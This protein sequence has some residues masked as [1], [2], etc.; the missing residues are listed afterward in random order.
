MC[1][2]HAP[3]GR[4]TQVGTTTS[5]LTPG[6][7]ACLTDA[8]VSAPIAQYR[9]DSRNLRVA[10][11]GSGA[12]TYFAYDQGGRILSELT[13]TGDPAAPWH[14]L[15]DYVWLDGFLLAQVEYPAGTPTPYYVHSDALGTPRALTN[16]QGALVWSTFQRPFGEVGE[17]ITP[18]PNTGRSVVTN[19]RLPGQY[20]ERLF[21]SLGLQGPYYNWN[22]WYLPGV[23]RYLEPDPIAM[24]GGFNGE[25]GP[26]WYGYALQNPMRFTDASGLLAGVDDLVIGGFLLTVA[27]TGL[28]FGLEENLDPP[29][30]PQPQPSPG[31]APGPGPEPGPEPG[32]GGGGGDRPPKDPC[33][34]QYEEATVRCADAHTCADDTQ[35]NAC[36]ERAWKNYI[37]CINGLP[38]KQN[39]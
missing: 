27:L 36:M 39:P 26:D 33:R 1:L 37:R 3:L 24:A 15:R 11:H 38:W 5:A 2:R 14:K 34:V 6:G 10:R 7:L 22:R 21:G 23:G 8:D 17:T 32:P 12:W 4:L 28:V 31:P 13:P 35:Y 9:Y 25:W 29:M 19:L 20:D 30:K 16:A 18:D